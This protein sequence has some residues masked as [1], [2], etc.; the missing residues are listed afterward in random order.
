MATRV[1]TGVTG[2]ADGPTNTI[3]A[4]AKAT[5]TGNLLTA[6]I[7]WE[8]G[9]PTLSSLADTAGNT[10]IEVIEILH[11]SGD[12]HG[13]LAYAANITGNAA[14]VVTA[15]FSNGNAEYRRILVEE[16][17]G[18]A[19]SSVEDGNEQTATGAASPFDTAAITTTAAGLVLIG[20]AAYGTLSSVAGAGS[21]TFSL[22]AAIADTA[23]GYLLSSTAQSV[24]PSMTASGGGG[25]DIAIAQAFK[26]VAVAAS[27]LGPV[28]RFRVAVH[29]AST[30]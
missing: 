4:A 7:K 10:W 2:Q 6:V 27:P 13:A 11:P 14:N 19:I 24:T 28:P 26:N 8:I 22:A 5:T 25:R 9:S 29:R 20:V 16:W 1:G 21:P 12:L 18:L 3:A 30:F 15:T 17:A 23:C